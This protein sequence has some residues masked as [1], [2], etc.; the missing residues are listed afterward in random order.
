M[1]KHKPKQCPDCSF[2]LT[3]DDPAAE[4]LCGHATARRDL[5]GF[6]ILHTIRF[7]RSSGFITDCGPSGTFFEPRT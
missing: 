5:E 2:F 1:N 6:P 3:Q 7:Q 4:Y